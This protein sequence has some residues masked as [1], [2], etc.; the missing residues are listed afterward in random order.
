MKSFIFLVL[1]FFLL[2]LN[3]NAISIKKCCLGKK[4]C[5]CNT[6]LQKAQKPKTVFV[7]IKSKCKTGCDCN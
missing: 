1:L 3:V 2:T 5:D 4:K 7:Q 6:Y